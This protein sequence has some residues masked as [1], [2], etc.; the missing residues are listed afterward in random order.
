[1][2]NRYSK[3]Q[4]IL[5]SI[6]PARGPTASDR[7]KATANGGHCVKQSLIDLAWFEL[8]VRHSYSLK[9]SKFTAAGKNTGHH[10]VEEI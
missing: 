3:N 2:V 8:P 4:N 9:H 1:M 7:I 6:F 5:P 10:G